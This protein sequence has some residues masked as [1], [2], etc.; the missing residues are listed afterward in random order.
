MTLPHRSVVIWALAVCM[1]TLG[2]RDSEAG[3]AFEV[4]N[5]SPTVFL[6]FE[7]TQVTAPADNATGD[8]TKDG[9]YHQF[10]GDSTPTLSEDGIPAGGKAVGFF[11]SS[12]QV[13]IPDGAASE[14]PTAYTLE[15][16]VK[17]NAIGS[18]N[19][20]VRTNG[21]P[22]SAFSHQIRMTAGGNFE[23]Y[24]YDGG[25]R[26]VTGTT[27]AV[28]N[29]WYHV[30]ATASNSGFLSLFVNGVAEGTPDAVGTLWAGGDEYRVGSIAGVGTWFNGTIDE[31]AI[32]DRVLS[33]TEILSHYNV[34]SAVPVPEPSAFLLLAALCLV[35]VF[36]QYRTRCVAGNGLVR[37]ASSSSQR[38]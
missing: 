19:I 3:Y 11:T 33:D 15:A 12:S 26:T 7:E 24:T 23:T 1:G 28:A 5:D 6:R 18:Q 17:P 21:N 30:V 2:V 25:G 27:T 31:L 13:F 37:P 10:Q 34:G 29:N 8:A 22:V 38:R 32:Y 20:L 4:L 14:S 16:W 35:T 36:C 9:N